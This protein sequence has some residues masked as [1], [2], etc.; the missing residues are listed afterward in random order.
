[1]KEFS[2]SDNFD[3]IPLRLSS[4]NLLTV[5]NRSTTK[6]RVNDLVSMK[7][8]LANRSLLKIESKVLYSGECDWPFSIRICWIENL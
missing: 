7:N 2:K 5:R 8:E 6:K 1:M 4:E 3:K